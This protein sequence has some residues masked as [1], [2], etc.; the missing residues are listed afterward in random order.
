MCDNDNKEVAM[1]PETINPTTGT[2]DAALLFEIMRVMNGKYFGL[3]F[4]ER[5]VG[6]RVRL[7]RL[8]GEGRIRAYKGNKKVQNGKWRCNA[9][10]VLRYARAKN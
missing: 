10:D 6:S 3:R 4:S 9:A 2:A 7:D 8:I 1:T 5:I